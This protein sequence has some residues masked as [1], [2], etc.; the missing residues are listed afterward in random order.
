MRRAKDA[1]GEKFLLESLYAEFEAQWQP[2]A[3]PGTRI[4][5]YMARVEE[6]E[7]SQIVEEL[8][9]VECE[10]RAARGDLPTRS[11]YHKRFPQLR[12]AVDSAFETW[13]AGENRAAVT[14][15]T[16]QPQRLGDYRIV[17]EIGRGGMG[18]VYEAVQESLGRRVAIKVLLAHPLRRPEQ[19]ARF[20]REARAIGALHHTNIVE[21]YGAAQ[22]DGLHYFAM[23]LVE[24]KSLSQIIAE[25]RHQATPLRERDTQDT[26]SGDSSPRVNNAHSEVASIGVQVARAM[27]YAHSRGV[28][29]RDIKPSNL[30]LDA[31][32]TIWVTDFGL[33]KLR[34]DEDD[35]TPT[36][37]LLGTLRYLPPEAISGHWDERGDVYSLGVTL[38]ELLTLRPAFGESDHAI[39]LSRIASGNP[40]PRPR[41]IDP[42]IRRD[43]ETIVMKALAHEPPDRYQSAGDLA[44]DLQRLIDGEPIVARRTRF[45]ERVWKWSRRKPA[46]AALVS[47]VT[48]VAVVGFP[49]LATLW[50][51]AE[52]ARTTAE[53]QQAKA[54]AAR[55][56]AEAVGYAS[57]M[58]L[59]QKHI[60]DSLPAEAEPLL[61]QWTSPDFR[62]LAR[63]RRGWEWN[64]LHQQL[65][66][67]LMTLAG[68]TGAVRYVA[69]R[70][71]DSQIATVGGSDPWST[72]TPVP[73]EVILW[74]AASG[75]KQHVLHGH[76]LGVT[77]AAYSPD[78]SRL[79]TV[80]LWSE[81]S[82]QTP[83]INLW[84]TDNG[85][86]LLTIHQQGEYDRHL[87]A[88]RYKP[89][90][91]GVL[92][93][94]DGRW[95]VSW[96]RPVA[97]WHADTGKPGSVTTGG[98]IATVLPDGSRLFTPVSDAAVLFELATGKSLGSFGRLVHPFDFA[99][100]ADGKLLSA[101]LRGTHARIW[102]LPDLTSFRDVPVPNL[103]WGAI[104]PDGKELVFGDRNGV[105][106][107]QTLDST[108]PIT[109]RLGHRGPIT[110]GT[111]THDQKRVVTA[112][113]DG[114]ARVWS[115]AGGRWPRTLDT[116]MKFDSL[117]DI[118]F[119]NDGNEVAYASSRWR[120]KGSGTSGWLAVD[121]EA[122]RQTILDT[123]YCTHWPRNDFAF[124][125]DGRL[126]AAPARETKHPG[127]AIGYARS[128]RV[129]V[130]SSDTFELL[131]TLQ[132]GSPEI[133]SV[134]WSR[135]ASQLA[136][137]SYA[138]AQSA[139][140]VFDPNEPTPAVRFRMSVDEHRITAMSFHVSRLAAST[141]KGIYEASI[142]GDRVAGRPQ[143]TNGVKKTTL[144]RPE[145][146]DRLIPH[147]S[148]AAFLDYSPT[149]DRLAAAYKNQRRVRV[150]DVGSGE[151]LYDISGP[152]S[153]GCVRFS[154]KGRRLAAV[155]YDSLVYLCDAEKGNRLIAL[156]GASKQVGTISFT[157]RVIFSRDGR[158]IATND[159][160]GRITIWEAE[161][162]GSAGPTN[163]KSS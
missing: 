109:S 37:N 63:D 21:V 103:Y 29:H 135:D 41:T 119:R 84:D 33:A 56:H 34:Q 70:P 62:P 116:G 30:L 129:N 104:G 130:W 15:A 27:Q 138:N 53:L 137:A 157:P 9:A 141:D 146:T 145:T 140:T 100:S 46:L 16:S 7:R 86:L 52:T 143:G 163:G 68:H 134:A 14:S 149:G 51:N 47:V 111:F 153:V 20:E 162:M 61:R 93:S 59:A 114:T 36:G 99:Y 32:G 22:Q 106:H 128:G 71:D 45:S 72:E 73:G 115:V 17:R 76:P 97:A 6:A 83:F 54:D 13:V 81:R 79:A 31:E 150:Y 123:T 151:L 125:H 133:T 40:P 82:G 10:L 95:L 39:L 8:V 90:L 105:L 120:R 152:R 156:D 26:G 23:Q 75:R 160:Q 91:P 38:Y 132:V 121:G 1:A 12:D 60:Q 28:L 77:G 107:S 65:D 112:S 25:W 117:G 80:G 78:G 11:E 158:R 35:A 96:P 124:S 5:D 87:L 18:V 147:A 126:L 154:P 69:V 136:V 139:I 101:V 66:S 161:V 3:S 42:A 85:S 131:Q 92:F 50:R 74:D 94:S 122:E 19:L 144:V 148:S 43:L 118:S 102:S 89:R 108:K 155:G 127:K 64:Y 55:D 159:W 4:E 67:S 24:G 57:S 58:Q 88:V 49:L 110:H 2:E 44:D 98:E 113:D 48:L 142:A